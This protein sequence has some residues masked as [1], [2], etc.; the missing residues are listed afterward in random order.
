MTN[1]V[2]QQYCAE[3]FGTLGF[4]LFGAGAVVSLEQGGDFGVLGVALAHGLGIAALI[5]AVGRFSEAHLNPAVTVAH[6][7]IRKMTSAKAVGYVVSQ[8]TGGVV[9]AYILQRV[10]PVAAEA[11]KVGLPSLAPGITPAAGI[12]L[13]AV[14]TFFLVGIIL[15]MTEG[16]NAR[17]EHIGFAVGFIIA[18]G[19]L[20]AGPATGGAFN[21]ARAFGPAFVADVW[22]NHSVWWT[23]PLA[24]AILAAVTYR[25]GFMRSGR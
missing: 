20:V 7:V 23:G 1:N 5:Y 11:A 10:L 2:W 3:F 21:P 8:L 13:E 24:G 18:A 9:A 15:A 16:E 17:R 19:I 12:A 4:V 25:V 6:W 22:T 14:F